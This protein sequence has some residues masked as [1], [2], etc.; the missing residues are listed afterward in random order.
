MYSHRLWFPWAAVILIVALTASAAGALPHPLAAEAVEAA[1]GRPHRQGDPGLPEGVTILE[2]VIGPTSWYDALN[3]A[4]GLSWLDGTQL[5]TD[6]VR[7]GLTEEMGE[8][9]S[10]IRA[11]AEGPDGVLYVG[12][13]ESRLWSYDPITDT[14][15]DLGM[16][17]PEECNN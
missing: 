17:V 12:T 10:S 5:L 9:V 6:R 13:D 1:A 8:S 2:P 14:T 3:D 4:A 7:L 16:P 15:V 11:L